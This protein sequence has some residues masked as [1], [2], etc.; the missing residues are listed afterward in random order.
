VAQKIITKFVHGVTDGSLSYVV[1]SQV[2]IFAQTPAGPRK[3][4]RILYSTDGSIMVPF[5]YLTQKRG[6]LSALKDDP[7][8][9][10]PVTYELAKDGVVVDY[11]VKYSHHTT[12][13][14]HFSKTG[15]TEILPG[16]NC[17]DLRTGSGVLFFVQIYDLD[18][19][20]ALDQKEQ[21]G[22][23]RLGMNFPAHVPRGI[24][25]RAS[26]IR[27]ATVMAQ[28]GGRTIG[29]SG[30]ARNGR[31]TVLMA[32]P[33]SSPLQDHLLVLNFGEVAVPS[34]SDRPTM[35]FFGGI[36]APTTAEPGFLAFLY[37]YASPVPSNQ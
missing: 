21:P 3:V 35:V 23:F 5:P 32:Q 29:P 8:K 17:F 1:S 22:E 37:P 20:A 9:L 2:L 34:G 28:N 16:R 25:V 14:V 33:L 15:R 27:K 7:D 11:D 19:L 13:R 18:G 26:W 30:T 31:T 36:D 6:I 4:C 12:G 10:G 24:E